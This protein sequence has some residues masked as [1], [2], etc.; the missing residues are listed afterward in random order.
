MFGYLLFSIMLSYSFLITI[1]TLLDRSISLYI[2]ATIYEN[3]KMRKE[4]IDEYFIS[5][6]VLKNNATKKR[7]DE[8][9]LSKN[10]ILNNEDYV[11]TNNG[12]FIHKLNIIFSNIYKTNQNYPDTRK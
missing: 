3:E 9:I 7:L 12:K 1:P 5:G 10:I 6:F 4:E 2:L 8:Q 11:I